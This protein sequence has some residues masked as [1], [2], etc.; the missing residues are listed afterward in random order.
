[1]STLDAEHQRKLAQFKE[2]VF[3]EEIIHEG[4]SIGTDD[5]TLLRFLRARKLDLPQS[6]L[7]LKNCQHWRKTVGEKG[8]DKL[9][10]EINPF[11]YPGRGE[12]LKHWA[13]FVHKTDKQ[14]RPVSVQIFRELNLPELYKHITPEKHWD[15][16]CVNADNL[17]RE[18]LP[19]SSRAAG[20]HI[21]TA[22]VITDLKGFTL[23]QFWQVKSLARSSFQISQDY[24]P[25]TM[26]R[27]A[28]INAPSSFT[29][30]WNVVKR[31]LSKETQEK[32]DILGV[33]YRDRLLELIDAENLPAILGGSCQCKEGCDASGAGPWMDERRA[34]ARVNGQTS[35]VEH[36]ANLSEQTTD[37]VGTADEQVSNKNLDIPEINGESAQKAADK[38]QQDADPSTAAD[39]ISLLA[40]SHIGYDGSA[41]KPSALAAASAG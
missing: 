12:V 11:D 35:G 29:F 16:I 15:A 20:R 24:F 13:M 1:M 36:N 21:G 8:I 17:T 31:W 3:G 38:H 6:K 30:I 5:E 28:I 34:R 4:D 9:H 2:E 25:E 32:I 22:F 19:S 7:M 18:I 27:L 40:E 33:D 10:E 14:G 37:H 41:P 23:S 39:D 26:G